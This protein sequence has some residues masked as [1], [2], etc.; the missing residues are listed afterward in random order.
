M[1]FDKMNLV[2]PYLDAIAREIRCPRRH[3]PGFRR[4]PAGYQRIQEAP[5]RQDRTVERT[6]SP[7][8][9]A[10][11]NLRAQLCPRLPRT[12]CAPVPDETIY[13]ISL[14]TTRKQTD[15][16]SLNRYIATNFNASLIKTNANGTVMADEHEPGRH[17]RGQNAG[18][19]QCA[20]GQCDHQAGGLD[21][22]AR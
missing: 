5:C 11:G 7:A 17:H 2:A 22:C 9:R 10:A 19:R 1:P 16:L 20:D 15:Y 3:Q 13:A 18:R 12:P 21:R 4:R 14:A 8:P 6:G